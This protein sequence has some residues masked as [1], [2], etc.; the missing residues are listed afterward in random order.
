MSCSACCVPVGIYLCRHISRSNV[1]CIVGECRNVGRYG[2]NCRLVGQVIV[3]SA[4]KFRLVQDLSCSTRCIPVGIY[5]CWNISRSNVVGIVGK[6]RNICRNGWDCRLVGQVIVVSAEKFR[7]V[8]DLSCSTRCIPVGIY[9]CWNISRSNVV[10]IV[11]KRGNVGRNNWDFWTVGQ[12]VV[13]LVP[14]VELRV[15]FCSSTAGLLCVHCVGHGN[16]LAHTHNLVT[17]TTSQIDRCLQVVSPVGPV[18]CGKVVACSTATNLYR[19]KTIGIGSNR[20][21]FGVYCNN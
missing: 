8:Q 1:V 19:C 10:G 14:G 20:V 6:C 17:T 21:S 9:L 2:W 5:L 7:L 11:C 12:V 16:K 3:V 13:V 18:D 15:G 4:E